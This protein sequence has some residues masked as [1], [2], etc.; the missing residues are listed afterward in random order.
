[1]NKLIINADD[2]GA[3]DKINKAIAF[4]LKNQYIT[5]T[6]LMLGMPNS[7]DA[8]EYVKS[9]NIKCVGLHLNLSDG[10]SIINNKRKFVKLIIFGLAA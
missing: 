2:F 3:S 7:A 9:N 8:I 10:Y 6:T 4:L 1:M 5:S